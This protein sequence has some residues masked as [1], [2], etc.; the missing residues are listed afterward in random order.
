M[1]EPTARLLV[2]EDDPDMAR[3]LRRGL[4]AEGYDVLSVDNGV[5]ALITLRD[6]AVD[7]LAVDVMLPGMS[8]FELQQSLV[9]KGRDIPTIFISAF[10][11]ERLRAKT[12]PDPVCFLSKPFDT[13][14]LV[15]CL[16]KALEKAGATGSQSDP[17][18]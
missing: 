18:S 5:D 17:Q 8:G 10:P 3:L 2:V 6:T 16:E 13:K 12:A 7:A 15:D 1:D 9:A 4:I 14:T 11:G